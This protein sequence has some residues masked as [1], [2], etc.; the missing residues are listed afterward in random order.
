M[1]KQWKRC[2]RRIYQAID[3]RLLEAEVGTRPVSTGE[4]MQLRGM[5]DAE[6]PSSYNILTTIINEMN[7]LN[8]DYAGDPAAIP[9]ISDFLMQFQQQVAAELLQKE[10]TIKE[11]VTLLSDGSSA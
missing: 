9:V 8:H 10:R 11:G 1:T 5:L 6:R 4:L 2:Y 7:F 3:R